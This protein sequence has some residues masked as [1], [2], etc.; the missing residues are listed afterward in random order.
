MLGAAGAALG[1]ARVAVVVLRVINVGRKL[2]QVKD[3]LA[4]WRLCAPPRRAR[5]AAR[6]NF[7]TKL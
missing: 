1:A 3:E 7:I 4:K 2:A 5:R 6:I